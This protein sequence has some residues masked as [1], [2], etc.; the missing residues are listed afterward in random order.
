ME[1]WKFGLAVATAVFVCGFAGLA[2]QR[3]LPE[4]HTTGPA[5]EMIGAVV[6]LLSLL[7][8]LVLG[9]LIWTAYGVYSGQN[10]AVQTL[11]AKDLQYDL[12]LADYGPDAAAGRALLRQDLAKTLDEVWGKPEDDQGF[13][14]TNFSAAIANLRRRQS[15]LDSLAP[16]TDAQRTALAAAQATVEAISQTRLQMAFALSNPVS[17]P[18]VFMVVAWAGGLFFGFGIKSR[19]GGTS[20]VALLFG[21][22]A[23]ASAAYIIVELSSPYDGLFQTSPAPLQQ[24]LDYIGQGQGAVGAE[25]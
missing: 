18:L 11:A 10:L 13:R 5:G 22:L 24:V 9:L 4:R 20:L 25:R 14:A 3:T 21:A 23:V 12:A 6:G 16:A 1:A 17:W 15:Y 19:M 7:S 2:L 8:A